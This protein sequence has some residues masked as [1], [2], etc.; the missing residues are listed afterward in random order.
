MDPVSGLVVDPATAPKATYQGQT[1]YFTSE[2]TRKAF[3]ETP[4]KFAKMPKQ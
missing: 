3:L 4:A 1:Y 2:Q